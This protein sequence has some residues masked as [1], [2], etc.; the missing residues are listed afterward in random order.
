MEVVASIKHRSRIQDIK[1]VANPV[2]G[3]DLL[4]VSSED[5]KVAAYA[6]NEGGSEG[7]TDDYNIVAEFAG[8]TS[9]LVSI[10]AD[11]INL[12]SSLPFL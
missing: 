1:F 5:K 4:L 6:L 9:R 3:K 2:N 10:S 7:T 11:L 12:L 8:N